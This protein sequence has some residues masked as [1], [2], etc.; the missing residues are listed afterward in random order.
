MLL[1]IEKYDFG[2]PSLY[3]RKIHLDSWT[4]HHFDVKE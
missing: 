4:K 3:G 1:D 2:A